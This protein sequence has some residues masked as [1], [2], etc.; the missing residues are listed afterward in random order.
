M[1]NAVFYCSFKLKKG[2]D[3]SEYLRASKKLNDEFISKQKGYISWQQ[4]SNDDLCS[5]FIV[6]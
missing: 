5:D 2:V 1:K 6:F 3:I 4:L